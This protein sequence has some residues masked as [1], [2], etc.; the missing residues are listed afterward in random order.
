MVL[1]TMDEGVDAEIGIY[2][3]ATSF[4]GV[5]GRI[6]SRREDFRVEEILNPRTAAGITDRPTSTKKHPVY[7]MVKEGV[8]TIHAAQQIRRRLGWRITYLGLKDARASTAQY[9]SSRRPEID[10]AEEIQVSPQVFLKLRGYYDG[11]LTRRSLAGNRFTIRV[12]GVEGG[13]EVFRAAESGL[14]R[15][16]EEKGIPNF[17]GYQRFGAKR[18]VNHLVGRNILTGR[19]EEAVTTFLTYTSRYEPEETRTLRDEMKN[20]AD[21]P[22]LLKKME[23]TLDIER[24]VVKTLIDHPGDWVKALRAIPLPVRRLLV[25]SYQAYLFNRVLSRA[26]EEKLSLTSVEAGDIY[27]AVDVA[28]GSINGARRAQ[29]RVETN[30]SKETLPL[31]QLVGYAFR[32]GGGKFDQITQNILV[33]E[34]VS[35]KIFYV[36]QMPELSMEGDFRVPPLL[37]ENLKIHREPLDDSSCTLHFDLLKGSYATVILREAMKP[38]DP[39]AA[40][41]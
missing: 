41:F 17:Y 29:S 23:A 33:E 19:F 22:S 21:Y 2:G 26:V 6:R 39:V 13:E 7:I 35:P 37:V 5:G 32:A 8:D 30:G 20:P 18:P 27:G 34:E 4:K 10:A 9:V 28:D 3:Y 31:V 11:F 40:G 1:T 38:S 12:T 24:R 14:K 15:A 25:N 36:K 16:V